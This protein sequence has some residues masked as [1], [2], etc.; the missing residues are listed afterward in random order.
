M[1]KFAIIA[2]AKGFLNQKTTALKFS[3]DI[4][5]ERRA[6]YGVKDQPKDILNCGEELFMVAE[7]YN[8]DTDRADYE[9]DEVGLRKEVKATLEKFNLL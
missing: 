4:C 5:I 3:E 8:P 1:N 7:L 6:L 2:L 9:L